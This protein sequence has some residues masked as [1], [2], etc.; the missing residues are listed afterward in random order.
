MTP[1][2]FP[3]SLRPRLIAFVL[4]V[5]LLSALIVVFMAVEIHQLTAAES[6][7]LFVRTLILLGWAGVSILAL[8]WRGIGVLILRPVRTLMSAI[9]RLSRGELSVRTGLPES[10]GEIAQLGQAFDAMAAAK[11]RRAGSKSLSAFF[12]AVTATSTGI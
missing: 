8:A 6:D 1:P 7:Q 4:A 3:S 11:R 5:I 9:E 12:P 2:R 10:G